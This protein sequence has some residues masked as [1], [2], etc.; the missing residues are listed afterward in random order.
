MSSVSIWIQIRSDATVGNALL[1][2]ENSV[3]LLG[4]LIDSELTFNDHVKIICKKASQKLAASLRLA[5]ILSVEK[6]KTLSKTFS[7]S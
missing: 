2:E 7:E 1:W 5:Y 6:R 4:L 3:K